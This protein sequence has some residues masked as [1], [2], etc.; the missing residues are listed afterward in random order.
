[1]TAARE[2]WILLLFSFGAM[3]FLWQSP[4]AGKEKTA[5]PVIANLSVQR[6]D[7]NF[8]FKGN[9][10]DA[11][12]DDILEAIRSGVETVFKFKIKLK[13]PR[14]F[15]IDST[16]FEAEFT[17][18]VSYDSA[19]MEYKVIVPRGGSDQTYFTDDVNLMKDYMSYIEKSLIL[20][21]HVLEQ[22]EGAYFLMKAT[23]DSSHLF[24]PFNY[25]LFFISFDFETPTVKVT[26]PLNNN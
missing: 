6:D 22:A 2:R 25:I 9:L 4:C 20:R 11:F 23:L 15:W 7:N 16:L 26:M 19:S 24:F 1:M 14:G 10:V 8:L 18:R 3:V 12:N 13:K 21:S 17:H 5:K